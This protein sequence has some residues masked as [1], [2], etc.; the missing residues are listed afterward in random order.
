MHRF[1]HVLVC[2]IAIGLLVS[3]VPTA[4]ASDEESP[5]VTGAVE[6]SPI[7]SS[8]S[9]TVDCWDG[10]TRS[11]TGVT[12][13]SYVPSSCPSHRGWVTCGG[14]RTYCPPCPLLQCNTDGDRCWGDYDCR[15]YGYD[16]DSCVC[17]YSIHKTSRIPEEG[18]YCV[19]I[20]PK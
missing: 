1:A 7:E 9:A 15:P 4:S 2:C 10:S 3:F 12:P 18:G 19:C 6:G 20:L 11:C 8:C 16:C 5:F 14:V 13:C 17:D